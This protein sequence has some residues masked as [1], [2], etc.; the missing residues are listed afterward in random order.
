MATLAESA[1]ELFRHVSAEKSVQ[2]R[3]ILDTFAA[4]KRQFRLDL[5]PDDVQLEANWPAGPPCLSDIQFALSQLTEW[6]NLEAQHDSAR[7]STIEDYNRARF[8]YRLSLG[9]EA[10]EAGLAMFAYTLARKSEL[11]TVALDDILAFLNALQLLASDAAPDAAKVHSVLRELVRAF[12]GMAEEAQAFM[13]GVARAIEL[14]QA[15]LQAVIAFK[16]RLIDYLQRFMSDL[17]SRSGTISARIAE[18]DS[19]ITPL[20]VIAAKRERRDAAPGV[21]TQQQEVQEDRLAAWQERWRGLSRWFMSDGSVRAQSELLRARARAA[22]LQ[23]L[24]AMSALNERRNG[25]SDRSSD[26]R[27]LAHWFADTRSDHD[28]HRL[29]R[30]AF[31]LNPARHLSLHSNDAIPHELPA[32]TP[33][34]DAPPVQVHPR[35]REHGELSPRAP[36]PRV[37]SRDAGRAL[38]AMQIAD[39]REQI[40]TARTMLANGRV[41]R[42]SALGMLDPHAFQLLLN[43]LGDALMA[44]LRPDLPVLCYSADGL[45]QIR[46]EPVGDGSLAHIHTATGIFSGPDH[47]LTV[48]PAGDE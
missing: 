19:C 24:A 13:A 41:T 14:Q 46:L 10:A 4:A 36:P 23:L 20:L 35:L 22:I 21:P 26:F 31:A 9:G 16:Q 6:G 40:D 27:I 37:R 1:N 48:T 2:Y 29:W 38:L 43:L 15:D 39:E 28:A 32:S 11:Q 25:R 3:A 18:L 12:E 44:Q 8:L 42:L 5:R 34:R 7:V 17:V 33:W 45:L 47:L 30:A